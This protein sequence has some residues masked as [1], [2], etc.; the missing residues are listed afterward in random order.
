MKAEINV[1]KEKLREFKKWLEEEQ[2]K[3]TLSNQGAA[4]ELSE[5]E[6]CDRQERKSKLEIIE[7]ILA[8][9]GKEFET[10]QVS[11]TLSK[12]DWY[13]IDEVCKEQ[14]IDLEEAASMV[15]EKQADKIRWH[16]KQQSIDRMSHG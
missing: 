12:N 2:E 5:R 1:P 14:Y 4:H 9:V 10:R 13:E 6:K 8:E 16:V 11:I 3:L 15:M 7:N